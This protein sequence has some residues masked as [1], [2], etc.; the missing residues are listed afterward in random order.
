MKCLD[1]YR[2]RLVLVG[3][4]VAVGAPVSGD[5]TVVGTG[6][7]AVDLPAVQAAVDGGGTVTLKNG[8][9]NGEIAFNFGAGGITIRNEV[10]IQGED[11]GGNMARIEASGDQAYYWGDKAIHIDV[12]GSDNVTIKNCHI[13]G[14]GQNCISGRDIMTTGTVRLE[15]NV[16]EYNGK[17]MPFWYTTYGDAPSGEKSLWIS[18]HGGGGAPEE[19]NTRQ[20]ENQKHLYELHEGVY[21]APRAPT[22]TWNLWHQSHIDPMFEQL[23]TQMVMHEGV[24]PNKVYIVGYSAGGDGVYQLAPRMADRFAG[25]GMMAGHPNETVP[26]GLQNIAFALH[27]GSE[28]AA[29]DRNKIGAQWKEKLAILKEANPVG[30]EHQVVVHEGKGHWMEREEA[31][32]LDWLAQFERNPHP[33]NIVWVQDD[34]LHNQ[35]YWLGVDDPKARTKIVASIEG[36]VVTIHE[37]DVSR[38]TVYLNDTM[39]DIDK[40]IVLK[41][42]DKVLNTLHAQRDRAVIQKTLRD[43]KDYYTAQVSIELPK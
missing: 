13:A 41:F 36:Q 9:A 8:G 37:S 7:P 28:D 24:D 39:L 33:K 19:V 4:L 3:M 26:D 1:C 15:N 18:M 6:V 17:K 31:A 30:Y 14:T 25:A 22:N 16:I 38:I 35:F 40:P 23:I 5:I 32:A 21:V 2:M 27:V 11:V 10:T 42:K 12:G 29:Y 20:W 43:P 34:V